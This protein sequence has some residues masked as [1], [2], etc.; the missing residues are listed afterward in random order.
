M[1]DRW[2]EAAR[3]YIEL[4]VEDRLGLRR[5]GRSRHSFGYL[6]LIV[7]M[8]DKLRKLQARSNEPGCGEPPTPMLPNWLVRP[9]TDMMMADDC[10]DGILQSSEAEA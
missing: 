7:S 5:T 10:D 8:G 3:H 6:R 2:V 4:A 9:G 1:V